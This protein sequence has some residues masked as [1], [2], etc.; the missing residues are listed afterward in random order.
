M[1]IPITTTDVRLKGYVPK[2]SDTDFEYNPMQTPIAQT[3]IH[4]LKRKKNASGATLVSDGLTAFVVRAAFARMATKTID[5]QTYIYSNDFSSR[6][7]IGEL[8]NAADRGVKVRILLDDYGTKTDFADVLL[9]NQHPN[10][11]VK[12]FN[13]RR[14]RSRL[15]YIPEMLMDFNRLNSRMHNKLFIVDN[16]AL[17]TGGRNIG[18]DYFPET[19]SNFSDT[20]VL[21]LG[22]IAH[23]ATEKFNEYWNHHL[24]VPATVLPKAKSKIAAR[25]LQRTFEKLLKNSARNVRRYNAFI[26]WTMREFNKQNFDFCWGKGTFLAD[27]PTKVELPKQ[28]KEKYH[29]EIIIALNRLWKATKQSAYV[30]AAYFVPGPGGVKTMINEEK[31]GVHVTLVTNSLSSTN[32]PTVY[33]KWEKYR[34]QLINGGIDVYE[35]M[36]GEENNRHKKYNHERRQ[37]FFSVMHSKTIVFDNKISWI[38]SFNLDPRSAYYNTENVAIFESEKFAKKLR[39]LILN[40]TKISWHVKNRGKHTVW[41]GIRPDETKPEEH[42]LD[43]DTT[44]FRRVMKKITKF[45]PEK[46]V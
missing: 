45:I 37:H 27:L 46:L 14:H 41:T 7:L 12:I 29:S 18:R 17:I 34:K 11:E 42:F 39:D 19:T 2:I 38:G 9:L 4:E 23:S 8:K 33:S 44:F 15:L 16:I 3:Y 10:I 24:A 35:F 31:A 1:S 5:L 13:V 22:Q 30:S 6:I 32:A 21:F 20:D 40:D 25:R 26:T 36:R 43:P 28:R